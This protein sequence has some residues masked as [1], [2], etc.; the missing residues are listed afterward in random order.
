MKISENIKN[1]LK[2]IPGNIKVLAAVKTRNCE[3]INEALKAGI[4]IIGQNYVQDTMRTLACLTFPYKLHFIGH[5]QRNKV[6]YI[7]DKVDMIETV[8]NEKLA[9]VINDRS[10]KI[11]KVTNVLIEVNSGKEPQKSGVMPDKVMDFIKALKNF[12]SIK[13]LGLMTMAPYFE[14]PETMRPYFKLTKSLFEETKNIDQENYSAEIL[15]MGMSDS[16]KI[17][18]EEGANLVRIG[19]KI[20]GARK[21]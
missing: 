17:A 8:D 12:G 1:I 2:E 5:L 21:K 18:I 19:T 4:E 11:Q 10:L 14:D 15:S 16:Y 3:E 13:I 9:E 6:K 7:I 20:F